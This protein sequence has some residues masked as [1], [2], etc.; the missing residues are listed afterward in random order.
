[1][2]EAPTPP[3]QVIKQLDEACSPATMAPAGPRP[4]FFG[5]VIGGSLPVTL[6]ANWL[7]G[8]WDQNTGLY[9]PTPATAGLDGKLACAIKPLQCVPFGSAFP[10]ASKLSV[11]PA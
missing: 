7:A 11:F 8:A 2:P 6:A 3:E 9:A 5:F 4:R 10:G 1:L